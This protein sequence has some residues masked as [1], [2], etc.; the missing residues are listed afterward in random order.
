[1][2]KYITIYS[3]IEWVM[4]SL[5]EIHRNVFSIL[6]ILRRSEVCDTK[7]KIPSR[8]THNRDGKGQFTLTC[9][10]ERTY[11]E[12]QNNAVIS[13]STFHV[14]NHPTQSKPL[15]T[16]YWNPYSSCLSLRLNWN[17]NRPVTLDAEEKRRNILIICAYIVNMKYVRDAK[18]LVKF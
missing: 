5:C 18:N 15:Q 2:K 3:T 9:R 8:T 11:T 14:P 13:N 6:F 10:Y 1:M 12:V 17:A 7:R 16:F 4:F